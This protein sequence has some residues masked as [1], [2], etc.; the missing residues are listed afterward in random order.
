MINGDSKLRELVGEIVTICQL[1]S[2]AITDIYYGKKLPEVEFKEDLS[3]VTKADKAAHAIIVAEL[4]RLSPDIPILSEEQDIPSFQKRKQWKKYWLVDPLD[5]TKEFI[6]RNGEF[7]VN[8]ALIEEGKPLLGVVYVPLEGSA[9]CG[10]KDCGAWKVSPEGTVAIK[11]GGVPE[12]RVRVLM[13][14]RNRSSELDECLSALQLGFSEVETVES[15]SALKF[16]R[17]A[18][19]LGD[20]YPRFSPCCEWDTAAGQ[21]VLEGAGG[22]L[23]TVEYKR[24]LYNQRESLINPHFYAIG[25]RLSE[26]RLKLP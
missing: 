6:A 21:A 20:I 25:G 7:T 19:G 17:L 5:G 26:W 2:A 3:P 12:E 14:G 1:A 9:Y 23:L 15:G 16:C 11:V 18:E 24:F 10:A 8:I 4:S 13:S 22:E